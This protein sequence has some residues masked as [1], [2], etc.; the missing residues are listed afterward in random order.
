M[1]KRQELIPIIF[2]STV[3][4]GSAIV[5]ALGGVVHFCGGAGV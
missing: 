1:K 2:R 3:M 4:Y 5:L